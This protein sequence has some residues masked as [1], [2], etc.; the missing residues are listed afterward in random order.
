MRC[1]DCDL[2]ATVHMEDLHR[3]ND[4]AFAAGWVSEDQWRC[5]K[6]FERFMATVDLKQGTRFLVAYKAWLAAWRT[7]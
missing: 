6:E 7:K 5:S 1:Q 3:C 4:H 2:P